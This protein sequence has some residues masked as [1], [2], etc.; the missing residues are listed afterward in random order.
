MSISPS[1]VL[2]TLFLIAPQFETTDPTQLDRYNKMISLVGCM[3]SDTVLSCCGAMAYALLVAH[4][5]TMAQN[6]SAGTTNSMSEGDLSIQYNVSP[7]VSALNLT[8]FGRS[9]LDLI[10]RTVIGATVSNLPQAMGGVYTNGIPK[11]Y[12]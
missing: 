9:Y 5:L 12:Y 1:Q 3:V 2:D 7:D 4:Y 8:S 10:K 11:F 6:T